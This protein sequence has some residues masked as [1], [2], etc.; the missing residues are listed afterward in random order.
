MRENELWKYRTSVINPKQLEEKTKENM[1]ILF[2]H[3][4]HI[5]EFV[6]F[7]KYLTLAF[8]LKIDL[9]FFI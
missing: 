3:I 8:I 1:K 9:K 4:L 6:I 5:I 2:A 7:Y